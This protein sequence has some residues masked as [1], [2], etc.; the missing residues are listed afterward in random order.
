MKQFIEAEAERD[1]KYASISD[2]TIA[3]CGLLHDLCKVGCYQKEPKNQKTYDPTKVGQAQRYQIKHD[4]L[5]DFIWETVMAY[6]FDDPMPYGHG[7]KSVYIVSS[8]MKLTREESFAIR[9]HMGPWGNEDQNGPSK[10]TKNERCKD[11]CRW[12]GDAGCEGCPISEAIDKLAAY[13]NTGVSPQ[14]LQEVVNLFSEFVEP[15]VPAELK[16]WMER[17]IWHVQKCND[18][19]QE[20]V[21][22]RK[23]LVIANGTVV[24][25]DE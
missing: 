13:E 24:S 19:R 9:Y 11:V 10:K 2:E 20:I 22:L 15:H 18:Q 7:E 8:F 3:I 23:E 17:C 12:R 6:K 1:I 14:E 4:D 16:N 5:G 21:R 25:A